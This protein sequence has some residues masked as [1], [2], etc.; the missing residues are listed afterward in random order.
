MNKQTKQVRKTTDGL[1][2]FDP[3]LNTVIKLQ[4][5]IRGW[6]SKRRMAAVRTQL[7]LK[8]VLREVRQSR[9]IEYLQ[10]A[11]HEALEDGLDDECDVY[12]EAGELL[13]LLE[14][15]MEMEFDSDPDADAGDEENDD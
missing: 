9:D 1:A 12:F 5:N 6:L 15:T 2:L 10:E 7:R 11:I 3:F 4:R 8:K 13:E 14:E